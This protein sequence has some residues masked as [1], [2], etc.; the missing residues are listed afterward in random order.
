MASYQIKNY[1]PAR[2]PDRA[3]I[4]R[5]YSRLQKCNEN[6]K[7]AQGKAKQDFEA[8]ASVLNR[9][10]QACDISLEKAE[11]EHAI[12]RRTRTMRRVAGSEAAQK[13]MKEF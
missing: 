8:E 7:T 11:E 1:L 4:A 6:A 2:D 10:L 5:T 9:A 3:W 12:Y 13:A